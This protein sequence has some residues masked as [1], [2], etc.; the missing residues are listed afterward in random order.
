MKVLMWLN[1][2]AEIPGGH[3]VQMERTAAALRDLGVEVQEHLGPDEPEGT[4]DVVHGF[5]LGPH[6]VAAMRA[7]G[8]P[9]VIST[10]Y[11]GLSYTSSHGAERVTARDALGRGRRGLRYLGASLRGREDLTRLSLQEAVNDLDRLRAW[12][13]AE[14]LLPNADGEARHVRDDLGILTDC[15]VVPNAIDVALFA[16]GVGRPR[17]AGSVLCVGRVEPH[18]NQL[19]TIRALAGVPGVTLTVVGPPHPHH[20]GYLE[21]CRRAAAEAGNVTLLPGVDHADLPGLYARHRTHVLATWYETTGLVSLEAAASGCT[22]VT[23]D[24]GHAREYFGDDARYCDPADVESIRQ[25]VTYALE[26]SPSA[27]LRARIADRYT[28]AETARHTLTAYERVL[29]R[30]TPRTRGSDPRG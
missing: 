14:V 7:R 25:A 17:P 21:E 11:V 12:S 18:K 2:G 8:I 5:Q 19:G 26:D 15:V 16:P 6:E 13:M 27:G 23:T 30:R 28:W 22:V 20:L 4:W 29:G 24:R 9:V 10:I 3:R 1:R